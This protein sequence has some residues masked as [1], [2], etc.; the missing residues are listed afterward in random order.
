MVLLF[1]RSVGA[2]WG[3]LPSRS[4]SLFALW[5]EIRQLFKY[6]QE[7]EFIAFFISMQPTKD[8]V[9]KEIMFYVIIACHLIPIPPPPHKWP[10]CWVPEQWIDTTCSYFTQ[11]SVYM[12]MSTQIHLFYVVL[13]LG[14]TFFTSFG[15][16]MI[17]VFFYFYC[18]LL[19]YCIPQFKNDTLYSTMR[20]YQLKPNWWWPY[21]SPCLRYFVPIY[22]VWE[23][24]CNSF[25]HSNCPHSCSVELALLLCL[26]WALPSKAAWCSWNIVDFHCTRPGTSFL[27]GLWFLLAEKNVKWNICP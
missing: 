10:R 26:A 18:P 2:L 12:H 23:I 14:V 7:Y 3:Y 17:Q 19:L 1:S 8:M 20:K 24:L 16:C 21:L 15:L 4:V 27:Q 11:D 5:G 6:F 22:I 25:W 9:T 13:S